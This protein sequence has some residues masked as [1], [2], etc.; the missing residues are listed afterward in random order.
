[1]REP[2]A[3]SFLKDVAS[4]QISVKHS[5]G[6]YRHLR[7]QKPQSSNM[8]FDLVTWP[9]YLTI[10]GDMGC[11]TFARVSDMFTFFRSKGDLQINASYWAEKLEH[12]NHGGRDGAKVWDDE[13][14]QSRL[15][16]KVESSEL[17]EDQKRFVK[18]RIAKE[19]FSDSG[20]LFLL[21]AAYEFT[22]CLESECI[23]AG[24]CLKGDKHRKDQFRFDSC[25]IPSGKDYSYHFIWCLY[26]I[27]WGIQQ[28]YATASTINTAV[29]AEVSAK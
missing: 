15:M 17:T 13:L 27:V 4:H 2:T 10:S 11:W 24:F 5:D 20:E 9:G 26:A 16:E 3:E 21:H 28:W 19:V 23:D 14:F 18:A 6:V 8:W 1:M 25:E 29:Q 12:G 7:F 22:C